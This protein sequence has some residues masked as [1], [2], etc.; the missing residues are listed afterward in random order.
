[1][2]ALETAQAESQSAEATSD[3]NASNAQST[4]EALQAE[5][6]NIDATIAALEQEARSNTLNPQSISE[7]ISV[8]PNGILNGDQDAIDEATSELHR[9]LDKY[10]NGS[11][12]KI[13][14]T[15]ISTNS[16]DV[17]TGSQTSRALGELMEEEF[18]ELLLEIEG[19]E[20]TL[21]FESIGNVGVQPE[22]DVELQLFV[23]F[24]CA[25]GG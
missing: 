9:V 19:Q 4:A 20:P 12:C 21:A 6:A 2:I 16:P 18:P 14:F 10:V 24:G 13:G 8:D 25:P 5:Q 7:T 15:N 1:M 23:N 11:N 17:A 3:A 22:G